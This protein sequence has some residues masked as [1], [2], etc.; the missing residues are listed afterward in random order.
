MLRF[1]FAVFFVASFI[2]GIGYITLP[3]VVTITGFWPG[4]LASVAIWLFSV[5]TGF[6]YLEATLACP[7]GANMMTISQQL[8][9]PFTKWGGGI[10]FFLSLTAFLI[11]YFIL[12]IPLFSELLQPYLGFYIPPYIGAF[13]LG[14]LIGGSICLGR[15][16]VFAFNSLIFI[17]LMVVF[18]FMISKDLPMIETDALNYHYWPYL[19]FSLPFIYNAFFYQTAIPS[20]AE[21]LNYNRIRVKAVIVIGSTIAL[22]VILLWLLITSGS[23]LGGV[24]VDTFQFKRNT[25]DSYIDL[26]T[27]QYIDKTIPAF[28]FL[29]AISSAFATGIVLIDFFSDAF[30]ISI[31]QRKGFKRFLIIL[32]VFF[33]VALVSLLTGSDFL[34]FIHKSTGFM[35]IIITPI[36]PICWIWSAR[37]SY[38]LENKPCLFGGKPMLILL[39]FLSVFLLYIGGVLLIEQINW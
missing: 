21:F 10:L 27:L 28:I 33:F 18:Y 12:S 15:T 24:I 23:S 4:V 38:K 13:I 29:S 2:L 26:R 30:K 5:V 37:Y 22:V 11:S 9:G 32:V 25:L 17:L 34:R 39:T 8:L 3:V 16:W 19:L 35:N 6:L 31:D 36:I 14:C 20:I 7:K 1:I